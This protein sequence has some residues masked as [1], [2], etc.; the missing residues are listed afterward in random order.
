MLLGAGIVWASRELRPFLVPLFV[1]VVKQSMK[2]AIKGAERARERTAELGETME[3]LW[4]E[5]RYELDEGNR[6]P[7]P[8]S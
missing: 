5:A 2:A 6:N 7:L 8:P 4:A 1:P 3:D